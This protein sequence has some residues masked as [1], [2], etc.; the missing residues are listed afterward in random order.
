MCIRDR[1]SNGGI[2]WYAGYHELP[3]GGDVRMENFRTRASLFRFS[4]IAREFMEEHVEN[5]HLLGPADHLVTS[6]SEEFGGAEA[7]MRA[8]QDGVIFLPNATSAPT[9]DLGNYSGTYRVR[10]FD[11]RTGE[12]VAEGPSIQGGAQHTL[13]VMGATPNLDWIV[14]LDRQ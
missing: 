13:Q 2:E 1:F 8:G 14:F 6:A 5:F 12:E 7:M 9:V 10:W 3:L 11:P 4:R